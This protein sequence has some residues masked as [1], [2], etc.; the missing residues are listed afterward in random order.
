MSKR[1]QENCVP[2]IWVDEETA[3]LIDL[4]ES[5]PIL[6]QP[7]HPQH[8]NRTLRSDAIQSIA[9]QMAK[10]EDA[11]TRKIHNLQSQYARLRKPV[12]SGSGADGNK[13]PKWLWFTRLSFLNEKHE[14]RTGTSSGGLVEVRISIS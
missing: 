3:L 6:W 10:T 7:T 14:P 1:G 11:I 4:Y 2:E 5:N 8:F 12:K 9:V 13:A